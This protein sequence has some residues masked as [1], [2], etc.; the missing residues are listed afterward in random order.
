M[1][2][3]GGRK[4]IFTSYPWKETKLGSLG[5]SQE[6]K[7]YT[8]YNIYKTR[9]YYLWT[10]CTFLLDPNGFMEPIWE[11]FREAFVIEIIWLILISGYMV[12]VEASA[13]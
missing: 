3:F 7:S 12:S 6:E 1:S 9:F 11:Y 5:T 4:D 2:H 8:L 10:V 13:K